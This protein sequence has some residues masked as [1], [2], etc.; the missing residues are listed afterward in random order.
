MTLA[1]ALLAT[2]LCAEPEQ[3]AL[4]DGSL[5]VI[6]QFGRTNRE[7]VVDALIPLNID[8]E[9][10]TF[11]NPRVSLLNTTEEEVNLGG[12][13]R[14][15]LPGP[16]VIAGGSVFYDLRWTRHR[17]RF[18]QLG[19]GAEA[20]SEM[21]DVRFNYYFPEETQAT[22]STRRETS[23]ST[24]KVQHRGTPREESDGSAVQSVA[25][26]TITT[27]TIRR[28]TRF[29]EALRGYDVE[30]AWHAE[31]DFMPEWVEATLGIG[32][33]DFW[34]PS[35]VR[36]DGLRGRLE[37]RP[38]RGVAVEA[39]V[40]EGIGSPGT[41]Y[42]V[43]ARV[44]IPLSIRRAGSGGTFRDVRDAFRPGRRTLEE[45]LTEPVM[46]DFR[47]RTTVQEKSEVLSEWSTTSR[48]TEEET[49]ESG[50]AEE[51]GSGGGYGIVTPS[52]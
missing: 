6:A 32:Y 3:P 5:S 52:P 18:N 21:F 1:V 47:I 19:V 24:K 25:T 37:I 39:Q 16:R 48:S 33:H 44:T 49:V 29:E 7:V 38:L 46:R 4:P 22:V 31:L 9:L 13:V 40:F 11:G 15:L 42:F 43:G 30:L 27:T 12:V 28:I 8:P 26:D 51:G 2:A 10:A 14:R 20:L 36:F 35:G 23:V 50:D 17:H 45:R 41:G 34:G